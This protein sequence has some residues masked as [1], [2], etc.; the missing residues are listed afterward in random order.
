M[1][2]YGGVPYTSSL[3]FDISWYSMEGF[4]RFQMAKCQKIA[5]DEIGRHGKAAPVKRVSSSSRLVCAKKPNIY[6]LK[7]WSHTVRHLPQRL[8]RSGRSRNDSKVWKKRNVKLVKYYKW[9]I[10]LR[11]TYIT[12]HF[13]Y[14]WWWTNSVWFNSLEWIDG[15]WWIS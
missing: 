7:E 5:C 12:F 10:C 14:F 11:L 4:R 15:G 13:D 2:I 6:W 8:F 1:A 9:R 3:Q